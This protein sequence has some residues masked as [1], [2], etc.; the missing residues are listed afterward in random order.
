[1]D[2]HS[3][4]RKKLNLP[5][6]TNAKSTGTFTIYLIDS[7]LI[8]G[9][10]GY[11]VEC[12]GDYIDHDNHDYRPRWKYLAVYEQKILGSEYGSTWE[13]IF[14]AMSGVWQGGGFFGKYSDEMDIKATPYTINN[15]YIQT[16]CY[17]ITQTAEEGGC[18][19]YP[20]VGQTICPGDT[21]WTYREYE[22]YKGGIGPIGQYYYASYTYIVPSFV[23]YWFKNK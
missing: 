21:E 23:F 18:T 2:D 9:I 11:Q 13:V 22:Y 6:T 15:D 17:I 12:S 1:M 14:D 7:T 16:S 5:D 10:T 4:I 20:S 8:E 3:N 19:Y